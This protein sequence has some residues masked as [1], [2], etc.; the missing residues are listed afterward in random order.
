MPVGTMIKQRVA[1]LRAV[2]HWPTRILCLTFLVLQSASMNWYL[3]DN[4]TTTWAAMFSL[5]LV[6]LVLF[7][8]AMVMATRNVHE[9]KRLAHVAF[10]EV[11]YLPLTCI[12]WFVY[13]IA[14][15]I[16]MAVIFGKFSTDL[17]EDSFF[18]PNTLKTTLALAGVIYLSFLASQHD[19]KHGE[20]K[21]LLLSLTGI[22]LFDILDG[23]DNLEN[24][25]DKEIRDTYPPG[26]DDTVIAVCCINFLL[27]GVPLL[28]LTIT[29]FGIR[30]VP[31]GLELVHKAA[32][33]YAVNLPL[34]VTRMITW[35][36]FSQGISIFALKNL[37]AMGVTSFELM[38]HRYARLKNGSRTSATAN[39]D[40][41]RSSNYRTS[42]DLTHDTKL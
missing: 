15:D 7:I 25:F 19:L 10:D 41:G 8:C 9:E 27:A 26:L 18:G 11:R 38:E 31:K 39:L 34:F 21:E 5:D 33:A 22:V 3:M 37:I 20:R 35:H 12:A 24:L 14:L 42:N 32:V 16:K 29:K 17:D 4:L 40:D 36:G 30:K 6:V 23:V 13:A 1:T 28:T 2:R